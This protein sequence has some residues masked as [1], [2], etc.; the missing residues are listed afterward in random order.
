M[1]LTRLLKRLQMPLK[2]L[3]LVYTAFSNS[4]GLYANIRL[5]ASQSQPVEKQPEA[6]QSASSSQQARM[7]FLSFFP[8]GLSLDVTTSP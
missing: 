8:K 1:L 2:Q 7:S 6:I 5:A 3:H 4:L